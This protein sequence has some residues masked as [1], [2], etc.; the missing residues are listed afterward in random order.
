MLGQRVLGSA[1]NVILSRIQRKAKAISLSCLTRV[2]V[3]D[4]I[5]QTLGQGFRASY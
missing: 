4:Q 5:S 1:H 3:L 2:F